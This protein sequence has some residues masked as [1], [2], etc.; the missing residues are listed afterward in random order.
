MILLRGKQEN[1]TDFGDFHI[2]DE[3]SRVTWRDFNESEIRTE[4]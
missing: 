2:Y 4:L 1:E 3:S